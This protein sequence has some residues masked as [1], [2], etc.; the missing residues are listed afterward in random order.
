MDDLET[1]SCP[2]K[3][4]ALNTFYKYYSG[5]AHNAVLFMIADCVCI[6]LAT[7]QHRPGFGIQWHVI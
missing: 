6:R 7:S 3:Y 2:P 1:M 5:V 4:R